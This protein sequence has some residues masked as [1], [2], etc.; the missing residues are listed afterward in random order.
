MAQNGGEVGED[1]SEEMEVNGDLIRREKQLGKGR[2]AEYG[3]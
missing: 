3:K 2:K 1:G